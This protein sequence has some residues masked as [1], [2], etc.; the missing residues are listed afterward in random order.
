MKVQWRLLD[1]SE[2]DPGKNLALD[3]ALMIAKHE[4]ALSNALRFWN[5][6][7]PCIVLGCFENVDYA[8]D[9]ENCKEYGV[10]IVR[11]VSGGQ[12]M[13]I[14]KGN[15]NFSIAIDEKAF[16]EIKNLVEIL[17]LVCNCISLALK[18]FNLSMELD[19]YGQGIFI[20]N[21]KVLEIGS[22][23]FYEQTLIQGT[24]FVSTNIEILNKVLKH[25][26]SEY[27]T[28][29]LESKKS[30][31]IDEV[32][33]SIIN[34]FEKNLEIEFKAG[35]LDEFETKIAN[36]LYKI[37]YGKNGWNLEK[38]WPL[39]WKDVLIEVLV[40][41][42]LTSQCKR[43]VEVVEKA[44]KNLE[45][46]VELR[47]YKRGLGIPPGVTITR[48]LNQAAK[49]SII[50]SIVINGELVFGKE[51]PSEDELRNMII[52]KIGEV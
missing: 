10:T 22:H 38:E 45:E 37:K 41:Y 9:L 3:E 24:I 39:S 18:E 25:K 44:I 26:T 27:T 47:I 4:K 11:R 33:K 51:V 15:L 16:K 21:K 50:P 12:S 36:R 43:M 17:K 46:N 8:I 48:G 35:N 5:I 28:L 52:K 31:E 30:I 20:K 34:S 23:C 6:S 2:I 13:Y 19:P 42:P 29:T 14:D 49:N 7:I 1:Y 32:K 40:A